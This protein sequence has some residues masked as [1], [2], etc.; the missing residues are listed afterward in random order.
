MTYSKKH[1][2]YRY[3]GVL[4]ALALLLTGCGEQRFQALKAQDFSLPLLDGS[5]T[6]SLGD[7]EG[8]VVY[9]TFW[10]SW[11]TPCRQEMPYLA[12]LWERYHQQ[13]FQIVAINVE[14]NI[15]DALQFVDM[16]E[17]P[18]PVV[19]DPARSISGLYRVP[20]YPTHYIVD[21]RGFIRFSG[22][23]FN[24]SDVGAISQEVQTLV[25]ESADAGG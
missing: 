4:L 2:S 9:L 10:A 22:L 16:Y 5:G 18:F 12:Q 3:F 7:F 19:H 6:V 17:L 23:G 24:L 11:C 25:A 20:G 8:D 14:E 13:G 21:R 1:G 15:D